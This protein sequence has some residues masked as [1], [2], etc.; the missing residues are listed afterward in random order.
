M[1]KR[2]DFLVVQELLALFC[3]L[4]TDPLPCDRLFVPALLL[5]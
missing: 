3:T 1:E 2:T 5:L 4:N